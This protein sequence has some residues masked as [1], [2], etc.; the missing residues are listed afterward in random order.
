MPPLT[1]RGMTTPTPPGWYPDPAQ[2]A[3]LRWWDGTTWTA[4]TSTAQPP[5][6]VVAPPAPAPPTPAQPP[7]MSASPDGSV[8]PQF[9]LAGGPGGGSPIPEQAQPYGY[10]PMSAPAED[11]GRSIWH[12]SPH[13]VRALIVTAIYVVIA[14]STPFGLLGIVPIVAS[15]G[16]MQAGEKLAPYAVGAAALAFIVG[17]LKVTHHF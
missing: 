7:I 12:G 10:Q 8:L 13:A 2:V 17:M 15:I 16:S 6:P 14:I 4:Q 3:E 5:A 9:P 1:M 11:P